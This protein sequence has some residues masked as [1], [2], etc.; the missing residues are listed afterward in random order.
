MKK[1]KAPKKPDI[2]SLLLNDTDKLII[3]LDNYLCELSEY[4]EA[5]QKLSEAQKVFYY[6]QEL[7][8]EINNGG[9]NQYFYNSG[10]NFAHQTIASLL[11]INANNTANILQLAIDQ[12]PDAKVPNDQTERQEVLESIEEG[13]N[14]IWEALDDR[15]LE[16]EDNLYDLNIEFIKQNIGSF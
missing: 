12:F 3:D 13:A 5:L 4:G 11:Q 6:N 14:E 7:E 2:E 9:F 8:R 10:G 15:F 1:S 16:Y